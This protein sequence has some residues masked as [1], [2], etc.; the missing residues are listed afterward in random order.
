MAARRLPRNTHKPLSLRPIFR[1]NR[2][3]ELTALHSRDFALAILQCE[4]MIR[5]TQLGYA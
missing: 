5:K 3:F 1:S 4:N 2:I